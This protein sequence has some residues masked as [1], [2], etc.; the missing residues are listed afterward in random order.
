MSEA[1]PEGLRMRA[2][3]LDDRDEMLPLRIDLPREV[4]NIGEEGTAPN[5]STPTC[6]ALKPTCGPVSS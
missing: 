3:A 6:A 2:A 1:Q 5:S 4:G